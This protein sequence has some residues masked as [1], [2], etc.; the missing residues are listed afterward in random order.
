VSKNASKIQKTSGNTADVGA[1]A[2]EPLRYGIIGCGDMAGTHALNFAQ[3][4]D[5][6]RAVA[7][8]DIEP[9]RM[10]EVQAKLA[11]GAPAT[12]RYSDYRALLDDPAVEAV[13]VATPNHLHTEPVVAALES[14]RPVLCEKPF[15]TTLA[16]CDRMIAARDRSGKVLQ[17]GLVLRYA[18]ALQAM[19]EAAAQGRIGR[20]LMAWCH[21]LRAPFP[22]GKN[23]EWRYETAKSGGAIVEKD[24][25]HFD[26]FEW[27]LGAR[28]T[29]VQ[30]FG[31]RAVVEAGKCV[32]AIPSLDNFDEQV[33]CNDIVDHAVINLEFDTGAKACLMLCFFAPNNGLPFGV[34]GSKGRM[35]IRMTRQLDGFQLHENARTWEYA[36]AYPRGDFVRLPEDQTGE[37]FIV[38]PGGLR[39]HLCFH[40][41]VRKGTPVFCTAEMGRQATAVALAAEESVRRGGVVVDVAG[42]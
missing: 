19:A 5:L 18:R 20:P 10:D 37:G 32:E 26:L 31:G 14:G 4:P 22:I 36:E 11:A 29:R 40:E 24:C 27:M 30:A 25:H 39:Q 42:V 9:S 1:A 12:R 38:H 8:C 35:E 13:I 7:L 41:A 16:E 21:E 2:G 34:L 6:F 23:R 33:K 15:A 28:T 3:R 17:I